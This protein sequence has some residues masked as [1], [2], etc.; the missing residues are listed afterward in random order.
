MIVKGLQHKEEHLT[1]TKEL[2]SPDCA[3]FVYDICVSEGLLHD[4]CSLI[5]DT[6]EDAIKKIIDS[7]IPALHQEEYSLN[8]DG[9]VM[10]IL[11]SRYVNLYNLLRVSRRETG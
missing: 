11:H 10:T 6:R 1:S 4:D 2:L 5:L 8:R 3:D 7:K 9:V